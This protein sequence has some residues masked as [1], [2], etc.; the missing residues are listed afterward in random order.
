MSSAGQS[1]VA[2]HGAPLP[3]CGAGHHWRIYPCIDASSMDDSGETLVTSLKE[4]A[5]AMQA[6]GKLIIGIASAIGV[7]IVFAYCY[8][9]A[10]FFPSGVQIGDTLLFLFAALAFGLIYIFWLLVGSAVCLGI[11]LVY[12]GLK[13]RRT[14]PGVKDE[15]LG[16]G[17]L[18]L[19][20]SLTIL[21]LT[22]YIAWAV[23]DAF[24]WFKLL[25]AL[26]MG[27]LGIVLGIDCIAYPNRSTPAHTKR[28]RRVGAILIA[29]GI[30]FPMLISTWLVGR[31][32]LATF[33]DMGIYADNVRIIAT[34]EEFRVI[35]AAAAKIDAPIF[36]CSVE[37]TQDFAVDGMRVWWHGPGDRSLIA[38]PGDKAGAPDKARIEVRREGIRIVRESK[39]GEISHCVNL[40]TQILFEGGRSE[41]T[42]QGTAIISQ[43]GTEQKAR[44]KSAGLAIS[45]IVVIGHADRRIPQEA[46]LT[47]QKLSEDRARAVADELAKSL[48]LGKDDKR[49]SSAGKGSLSA[50]ATCPATMTGKALDECMAPDRRV[51]IKIFMNN[52]DRRDG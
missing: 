31:M 14:W 35:K 29:L 22:L 3:S 27:G 20:P 6:I 52:A 5:E 2:P 12:K 30:L 38:I 33:R 9:Y 4:M 51:D 10:H 42:P 32:E 19:L 23:L 49:I 28:S 37:G 8:F 11:N 24:E 18:L 43:L 21:G 34:P 45:N 48:G 1:K 15:N 41:L 39:S 36:S 46:G 47:N 40:D 26:M 16:L 17:L 44:M 25:A 13:A 50:S 7:L